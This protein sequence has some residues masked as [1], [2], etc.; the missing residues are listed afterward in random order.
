VKKVVLLLLLAALV[1]A[2]GGCL[3]DTSK[4]SADRNLH[5]M[6][7]DWYRFAGLDQPSALHARDLVPYDAYE[8]YRGYK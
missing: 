4:R 5:Y 6:A 2:V 3:T 1:V 7:D 8:P